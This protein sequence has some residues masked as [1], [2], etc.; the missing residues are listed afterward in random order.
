MI[1]NCL[2]FVIGVAILVL[3]MLFVPGC[4]V[5]SD[6][7]TTRTG[8]K[9]APGTYSQI[10]IGSTT[11][12]WVHNT[13]GDPTSK[14]NDKGDE[15]WKYTYTEHTDSSGAVFL[16]FGG[17]SENDVV[18]TVFIEFRDGIVVNKWRG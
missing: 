16:V 4:L 6:S 15:V 2:S 8:T 12:G 5:T 17:R 10:E 3:A 14:T 11:V 13:L 9:V 18:N 1:K 7:T